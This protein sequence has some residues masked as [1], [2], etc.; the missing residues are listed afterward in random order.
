MRRYRA[1][2]CSGCGKSEMTHGFRK[3]KWVKITTGL[4]VTHEVWKEDIREVLG[5]RCDFGEPDL[6]G[7]VKV[8]ARIRFEGV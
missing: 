3:P 8:T 2:I 4:G 1:W 6:C 7:H 5:A